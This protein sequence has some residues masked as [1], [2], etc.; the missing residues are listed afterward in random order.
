M[1][2]LCG[3]LVMYK[4]NAKRL[5][6]GRENRGREVS[7]SITLLR[8]AFPRASR[9][10]HPAGLGL[11]LGGLLCLP[12]RD[13]PGFGNYPQRS[14]REVG[15]TVKGKGLPGWIVFKGQDDLKARKP[16]DQGRGPI[17]TWSPQ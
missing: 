11:N 6:R 17:P 4:P 5:G 15:M 7:S 12:F 10:P 2:V 3:G 8:T 13:R 9:R 16:G 1:E 14:V